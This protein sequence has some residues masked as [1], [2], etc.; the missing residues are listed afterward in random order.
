[1]KNGIHD[2]NLIIKKAIF[3]LYQIDNPKLNISYTNKEIDGDITVILYDLSKKL[4]KSLYNISQEIGYYLIHNTNIIKSFNIINGFL[5]FILK[6]IYYIELFNNIFFNK[7]F[8]NSEINSE[9][10]SVMVEYSSPN[11]NKPLHI[12][13]IRNILLGNAI[14]SLYKNI[15][16]NVI[17]IQI[18][19]DRG[20]HICK[21]M[22]GWKRFSNG[23]NPED[24]G[25]KG[26]H[27]VGKYYIYFNKKLEEEI[28]ELEYIGYKKKE[29]EE[30]SSIMKE[31]REML[32]KWESGDP[33]VIAL[34]KKMNRWV[35]KGFI[36]TYDRLGINFDV[37]E[38]E[39]N[40]Y[41]LGKDI[42]NKGLKKGFFYKK[43]DG[44]IW[45]DLTDEGLDKKLL[46]RSDGTSVYITQDL[47][48]V[49]QRFNK[50]SIDTL[51]YVVGK[52]QEHHFKVLYS[53]LKKI[54]FPW[55][56]KIYHLSYGM[57]KLPDGKMNSRKGYVIN[58]DDIMDE[59]Y[60]VSYIL[61][62]E[63]RKS[64]NSFFKENENIYEIIGQGALKYHILKIDP[65]K[66]IKFDYNSSID[67]KG[68]TG[69]YIQYTYS[70]ICSIQRKS[71]LILSKNY[72]KISINEYE[73]SLIKKLEQYHLII[74]NSI[75]NLNPSLL[76]NYIFELSKI[77]ND[78]Y[79]NVNILNY[80]NII[81][82]NFRFNLSIFTG[83][84]LN[85]GMQILGINMPDRM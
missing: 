68:H 58:A 41:L 54:Q 23:K 6:D 84:I 12:G 35:Y 22:V 20:I 79:Q 55:I 52:E 32:R 42:I 34:W 76:A 57:V 24:I 13:H 59:M 77:F 27:F 60:N 19:N 51:I 33:E 25:M 62:K 65:K 7:N 83:K 67:F 70:R 9:K 39:S 69:T 18:F 82:S 43:E 50:Y 2:F 30:N 14:S 73:R 37:E 74:N 4:K 29:A 11:T 85:K 45:V 71:K 80:E 36:K 38:Y 16:R 66:S 75:N 26:D 5:N 78:F 3:D 40:T 53:I 64:K 28:K 49:I 44:S 1:M 72:K 63:L 46:L 8:F 47:G 15:G 10:L 31:A 81:Q 17:K 61:N 21:S 56:K 48:T